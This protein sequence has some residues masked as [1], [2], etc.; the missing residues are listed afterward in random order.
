MFTPSLNKWKYLRSLFSDAINMFSLITTKM[1]P[2]FS[3]EG[4]NNKKRLSLPFLSQ[5][6][7]NRE[8]NENNVALFLLLG[9]KTEN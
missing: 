6:F 1:T 3:L 9:K 7:V 8:H 2:C 4:N 5:E